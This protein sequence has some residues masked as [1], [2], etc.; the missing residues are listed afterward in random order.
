[1]D[2]LTR[3]PLRQRLLTAP[4]NLPPLAVRSGRAQWIDIAKG[5]SIS[6][7]VLWH[8]AGTTFAYNE[9]LIFLR[10]PLFFFLAGLFLRGVFTEASG[11]RFTFKFFNFVY[12]FVL[13]SLLVFVTTLVPQAWLNNTPVD[14]AAIT[15]IF[16]EP[17]QTLWFI[18]ALLVAVT[19]LMLLRK[20]PLGLV[21]ACA[22]IA[23]TLLSADGNWRHLPFPERV[24]LL[25]PFILL[26]VYSLELIE[27]ALARLARLWPLVLGSFLAATAMVY[28]SALS[29]IGPLTFAVSLWGIAGVI[30]FSGWLEARQG[31]AARI[32]GFVGRYSL[33]V[34]VLH[35]IVQ[36]YMLAVLNRLGLEPVSDSGA[37]ATFYYVAATGVVIALSLLVGWLSARQPV[38]AHLYEVPLVR[39]LQQRRSGRASA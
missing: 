7:V 33:Q 34:Y 39:R 12:L 2:V 21:L 9:A 13:W 17:P 8:V 35:R 29:A 6:L 22:L 31:S 37:Y 28:F 20:V 30:L 18:Y 3:Q 25:F 10:M 16:V 5:L 38:T 1:M 36:F 4:A 26:G 11:Q 23:Y 32:W 19:V 15:R 24:L 14:T 27:G